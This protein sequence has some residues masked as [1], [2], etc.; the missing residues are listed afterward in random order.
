MPKIVIFDANNLA[1]RVLFATDVI[2]Y[3]DPKTKKEVV[4]VD[5]ELFRLRFFE[6]VYLSLYKIKNVTSV[7]IAVDDK[8]SWRKIYWKKYKAH[9]KGKREELIGFDWS[10]Y[11]RVFDEYMEELRT[12]FP[13]TIL[14]VKNSEADDI[15]GVLCLEKKDTQFHIISTDKDFLQLS[16]KRITIFNPFHK[17]EVSHPNPELFLIEQSL[18]GQAKDNIYNIRTPLDYPEDKRKPGFGEA[19]FEKV[20]S[21]GWEKWLKENNLEERYNFNRNLMDFKRIPDEIKR[22]ILRDFDN[23]QKPDSSKIFRFFENHKW[24]DY[25]D[26]LARM[27]D[28]LIEI[29]G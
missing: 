26:N 20:L 8:A 6:S 19:A 9:R 16:C 28:K 18:C 22:R 10:E 13:F 24:S 12:H 29:G 2:Q 5:Y 21:Y 25:K 23:Y 3:K 1:S 11:Y 17:K 27:E 14:H 4:S 7:V 15:I